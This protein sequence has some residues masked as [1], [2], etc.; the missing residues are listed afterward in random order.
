MAE[1]AKRYH[2]HNNTESNLEP[3]IKMHRAVFVTLIKLVGLP[4]AT[5]E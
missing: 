1:Q 4:N 3:D 2:Q 5:S